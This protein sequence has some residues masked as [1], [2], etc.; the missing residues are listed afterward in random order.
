MVKILKSVKREITKRYEK[1]LKEVDKV[2]INDNSG[3]VNCYK[4]NSCGKITKTIERCKGNTPFG[5]ICP[6]CGED[7]MSTFYQDVAPDKP[8]E[9]EWV[10][11]TLD[12]CLELAESP[13]QLNFILSD[14]GLVRRKI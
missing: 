7:A 5:I 13:F 12:D 2:D 14:Y 9:Y 4:C 1:M 10:R 8:I 3:R 6:H 11:P